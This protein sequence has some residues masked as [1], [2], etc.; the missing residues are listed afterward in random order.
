MA[1]RRCPATPD[2]IDR[3]HRVDRLLTPDHPDAE[4]AALV[5]D[6][7]NTHTIGSLYE[8][9]EPEKALVLAHR[10]QTHHTRKARLLAQH[11]RI[12]LSALTRHASTASTTLPP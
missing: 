11:R 1:P 7:L 3:A 12:E 4:T 2:Q 5:M 6:D 10:L 9:S 8:A